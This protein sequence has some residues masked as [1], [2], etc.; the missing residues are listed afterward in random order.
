MTDG[1]GSP[2]VAT[3]RSLRE[4]DLPGGDLAVTHHWAH[5]T[6]D[7]VTVAAADRPIYRLLRDVLA[8][9]S[10]PE[11]MPADLAVECDDLVEVHEV[12]SNPE[13]GNAI[14]NGTGYGL[15]YCHQVRGAVEDHRDRP[16]IQMA[17]MG[18]SGSKHNVDEP[19][20]ARDLYASGYWTVKERYGD[21]ADD[22]RVLSAEHAILSPDAEIP[23]YERTPS[24]LRGVPVDSDAR[25]PNG[26]A[27]QDRLD[28]WA[29][30]VHNGLAQWIGEVSSGVD[31]RAVELEVCVGEQYRDPL[32]DRGVFDRLRASAGLSVSF[33]FQD[34]PQAAGGMGPQMEWMNSEVAA[35]DGGELQ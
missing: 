5:G 4:H 22:W 11:T 34:E 32:E 13:R 16:P 17:V 12:V 29:L 24:D 20:P 23:Y 7:A 3:Q 8:D 26:D 35:T 31:P 27:V 25:L 1:D 28:H 9:A 19:V 18:C 33:P 21:A 30:R 6:R 2:T 14:V 15:G 10:I